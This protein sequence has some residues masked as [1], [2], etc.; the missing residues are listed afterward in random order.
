MMI[1]LHTHSVFSDGT[2]PPAGVMESAAEAGIDVVALTD[3]DTT[4][5]WTEAAERAVRLGLTFVPGM[6]VSCTS[7][8]ISVH[9]LSYLHDPADPGLV[10]EVNK[11]RDSRR[12]RAHAIV[13]KLAVDFP[14]TWDDVRARLSPGAAVGRPHIADALIEVGVVTDR[15]EAFA[16]ILHPRGR[17]YA[18][19]YAVEAVTAVRLVRA[20]GGVPVMAHPRARSRGRVVSEDVLEEMIGAGLRG[21]EIDHRD[22]PEPERVRL[23]EI[24]AAHDLIVTGSSDYHGTGKANVLGENTTTPAALA[25]IEAEGSGTGVVRP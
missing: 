10:A 6:E 19:H 14:I 17:Y 9:L 11:A 12:H 21:L 5:G 16:D 7:G 18:T 23:R 25:A 8:G 13:D 4:A 24:A 15:T 3:H 1:D 20:A 2:Q 22:N